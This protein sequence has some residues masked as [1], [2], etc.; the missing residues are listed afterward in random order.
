MVRVFPDWSTA[1]H[2]VHVGQDREHHVAT[3]VDVVRRR[4][5]AAIECQVACTIDQT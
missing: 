1:E 2:R 3:A 5:R 4:P